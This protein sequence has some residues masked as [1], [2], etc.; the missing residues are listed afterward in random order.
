MVPDCKK[1]AERMTE[2][3]RLEIPK[4]NGIYRVDDDKGSYIVE[5]IDGVVVH[6]GYIRPRGTIEPAWKLAEDHASF[7]RIRGIDA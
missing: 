1:E 2:E 6:A 4:K 3:Y 7:T 5:V